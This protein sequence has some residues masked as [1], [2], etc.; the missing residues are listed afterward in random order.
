V[1]ADIAQFQYLVAPETWLDMPLVQE[2]SDLVGYF[3]PDTGFPM[4][5]H[6]TA[7]TTFR[8]TFKT[9][10]N[11]PFTLTLNDL[12]AGDEELAK[13]E[14]TA[15]VNGNFAITGTFSMQ[16]RVFRG[17]IPVTL[18]WTG[19]GWTY[20]ASDTTEDLLVNNFQVT[21]TYGGGYL[22]TTNQPRYLNVPGATLVVSNTMTLPDLYLYGGNANN[23]KAIG[24]GDASVVGG[25]YG[26]GNIESDG[27]VNFDNRVNI[28]DL[29]LVGGNY[30]LTDEVYN[31]WLQ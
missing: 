29:A 3:G 17:G 25:A 4:G 22:I 9:V 1:L 11:Y 31:D 18:T 26:T 28:Q 5:P 8:I 14:A 13:L 12:D 23:D 19:T 20:A 15:I 21:V 16:G 24:I 10:K 6:Y 2:G 30:G 27:D 7:T